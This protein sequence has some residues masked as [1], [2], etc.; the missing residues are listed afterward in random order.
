MVGWFLLVP[1]SLAVLKKN[2][3]IL[4]GFWK[5]FKK[6]VK[7]ANKY[8]PRHILGSK[9]LKNINHLRDKYGLTKSRLMP[10][11]SATQSWASTSDIYGP[12]GSIA[13]KFAIN[14]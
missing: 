14:N 9:I 1:K 5:I 4:Y 7:Q 13:S 10:S 2:G 6:A 8:H 12:S 11:P 3:L